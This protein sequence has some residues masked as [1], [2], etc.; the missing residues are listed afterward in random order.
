MRARI[1]AVL[2]IMIVMLGCSS[3]ELPVEELPVADMPVCEIFEPPVSE[4]QAEEMTP[5]EVVEQITWRMRAKFQC[6]E[7]YY[8]DKPG[9]VYGVVNEILLPRFDRQYSAQRVLARN[10]RD[11]SEEQRER[12]MN[13]FYPHFVQGYAGCML[14][15][16]LERLKVLPFKGDDT[17]KRTTVKTT[18]RLDDGTKAP[19]NYGMVKRESGWLMFDFTIEGISF[20]RIYREE[21]NTEI[22]AKGLDSVIER[23]EADT[24]DGASL[25]GCYYYSIF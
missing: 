8:A 22:K 6:N 15:F 3:E 24:S 4:M 11:A 17:K 14:V 18:M 19:A 1:A 25:M 21:V 13:A 23:L 12:F 20:V 7:D 16:N 5:R 10:W 2:P 9:Q